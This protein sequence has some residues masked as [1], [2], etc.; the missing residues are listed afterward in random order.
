MIIM[1]LEKLKDFLF[2]IFRILYSVYFVLQ[3]TFEYNTSDY[4]FINYIP[5]TV[6]HHFHENSTH[7]DF[8][9]S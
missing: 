4:Y 2:S 1:I 3:S 8:T 9:L 6:E 7:L 5:V